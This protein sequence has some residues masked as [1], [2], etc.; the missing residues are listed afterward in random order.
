MDRVN[1]SLAEAVHSFIKTIIF[2]SNN[3][4]VS[5]FATMFTILS[6]YFIDI[7]I[8]SLGTK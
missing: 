1:I 5:S 7:H 6:L 8:S 4:L 3:F 2:L